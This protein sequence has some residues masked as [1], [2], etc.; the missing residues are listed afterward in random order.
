MSQVASETATENRFLQGIYAPMSGENILDSLPVKGEVPLDLNGSLYRNGPNPVFPPRGEHHLFAGDGMAHAFH[1]ENG[2]VSY[3]NRWVRTAK[4]KLEQEHQRSMI[5]PMN[6]FNCEEGFME[7]IFTDKDGLANTALVSHA[8]RFLALEEGHPPFEIDPIT[9][10]SV[11][12]YNFEG[13]LNTAMTAHPKLDPVTGEMVFFAY[14][15]TGAFEP[16][17]ALHKVDAQG[18]LTESHI[19]PTAY[20]AMVHDF[21][22]TQNYIVFPVFPLTG[23]MDRAMEGKSPFAWE[24]DKGAAVGILPR[25]GGGAEDVRWIECDPVYVFHYMNAFDQD[26][27]I[28]VDGCQFDYAPL[29]PDAEGNTPPEPKPALHRWTIDTNDPTARVKAQRIDEFNSEFPQVDPRHAGAAYRYGFYTSPTSDDGEMYNA[30]GRFDH[31]TGAVDRF[32]CGPRATTFT[33]EALFV[34]RNEGADEGEGYLLSVVTDM[35][36]DRSHL[37]ILDAQNV[38]AGP[39]ATAQLPHRVPVGF[40]GCWRPAS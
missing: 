37:L 12:S 2:K 36:S 13:K 28:T 39:L 5:D 17:L 30:V 24:P 1:I 7:F 31:L 32:E 23:S 18:V 8:G 14:M 21:V 26:N 22:I 20:P 3:R 35:G 38:S 25:H 27:I 15:A 6:P 34:P 10:E 16:N 19:I 33:S 4:Y 9:L 11:G 29:F 40:H